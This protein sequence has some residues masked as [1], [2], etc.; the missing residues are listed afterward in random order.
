MAVLSYWRVWGLCPAGLVSDGL[1]HWNGWD[2]GGQR[3]CRLKSLSID[4]FIK[5][6]QLC[7]YLETGFILFH[8]CYPLWWIEQFFLL[9][10]RTH[11]ET[12]IRAMAFL[13]CPVFKTFHFCNSYL[14][15][16][17]FKTS[18]FNLLKSLS[19]AEC[20][21]RPGAGV[22][23]PSSSGKVSFSAGRTA[24]EAGFLRVF[25]PQMMCVG[26]W[27][28]W[29]CLLLMAFL[30]RWRPCRICGEEIGYKQ[31][32]CRPSV[33]EDL[34]PWR[35][36]LVSL[37]FHQWYIIPSSFPGVVWKG[38]VPWLPVCCSP[39]LHFLAELEKPLG[40]S[41]MLSEGHRK[42]FSFPKA[43]SNLCKCFSRNPPWLG[44]G[45]EIASP[46]IFHEKGKE[47]EN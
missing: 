36:N 26:P 45:E 2:E 20:G 28:F 8:H 27:F 38:K 24:G 1:R 25:C 47:K 44:F 29:F 31:L 9:W 35:G 34:L 3:S 6:S 7:S 19:P 21:L 41:F 33:A 42:Q 43:N 22:S 10:S 14:V 12:L 17:V 23:A 18:V 5:R 13:P 32:L 30:M 16:F 37:W 11:E 39:N 46:S 4:L 15:P 40:S